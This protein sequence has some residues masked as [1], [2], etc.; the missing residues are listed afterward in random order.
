MY[1]LTLERESKMNNEIKNQMESELD[2]VIAIL[3]KANRAFE[4]L[5]GKQEGDDGSGVCDMCAGCPNCWEE[6]SE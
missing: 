3:E 2:E 6:E 4:R 5:F 1:V